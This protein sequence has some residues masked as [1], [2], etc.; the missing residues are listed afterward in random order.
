[1]MTDWVRDAAEAIA[2]N[3]DCCDISSSSAEAMAEVIRKHNPAQPDVAYMPVPRC[4]SCRFW[5]REDEHTG[6]CHMNKTH[7]KRQT[8]WV[9]DDAAVGVIAT[10]ED[11]G[12][13][14]WTAK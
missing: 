6:L 4:V 7:F 13:V 2:G 9:D 1:M 5:T 12:C 3:P 14:Q 10:S 11:F 8:M